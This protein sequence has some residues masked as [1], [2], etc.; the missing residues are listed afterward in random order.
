MTR[1]LRIRK[2]PVVGLREGQT[3]NRNLLVN[4]AGGK[5]CGRVSGNRGRTEGEIPRIRQRAA[6]DSSKS[7]RGKASTATSLCTCLEQPGLNLPRQ[8]MRKNNK[9]GKR[10]C[11]TK[12]HLNCPGL[13]SALD[14]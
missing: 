5:K 6:V 4:V 7:L 13:L 10:A 11:S 14:G 2:A 8:R 9:K 12:K 1:A 3:R